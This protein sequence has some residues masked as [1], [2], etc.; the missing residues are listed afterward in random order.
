MPRSFP[1][2]SDDEPGSAALLECGTSGGAGSW[3][4]VRL[5]IALARG[6]A[7]RTATESKVRGIAQ[8]LAATPRGRCR[9]ES[10]AEFLF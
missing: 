6:A 2:A 4:P 9:T 10:S 1:G 8:R 5:W 7:M 3:G